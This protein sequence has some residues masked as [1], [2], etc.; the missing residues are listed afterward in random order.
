MA[1]FKREPL[2]LLA[3]VGVTLPARATEFTGIRLGEHG[4][5]LAIIE[6]GGAAL[7]APK[8]DDQDGFAKPG[9][10]DN[11]RYAGWLELFPN[12]GASYSQ[13]MGLAV[14]DTSKRIRRFS[15]HFGMVFGWCFTKDSN[16][17][18]YRYQFP[19]GQ[20]PTGFDMR[21]LK[22]GKLLRRFLLEPIESDEDESQLIRAKAP[23][24][25]RCAH[26]SATSQ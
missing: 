26:E 15:G 4:G 5:K 18:I 10:S 1:G 9:V 14:M 20:T 23:A 21:R 12:R 22:D 24:W 2:H 13:P 16:A 6:R 8:I 7:L 11:H 25:T 19:H 3:M 17:V